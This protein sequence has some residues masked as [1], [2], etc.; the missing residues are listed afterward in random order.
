MIQICIHGHFYQPSRVNPWTDQWARQPSAAPF[1]DWNSRIS[2]ECYA[3]NSA[4]RLLD[5]SGRTRATRNNYRFMSFDFGPTL[6][7]WMQKNRPALLRSIAQSDKDSIGLHGRGTAMAQAY[8]HPI[9]P[10]CDDRDRRLEIKWGLDAFEAVFS[11][12][13]RGLWMPE[14]AMDTATLEEMARQGVEF[15]VVDSHQIQRYRL[16][17]GSAWIDAD[18]ESDVLGHAYLVELPSGASITLVPYSRDLSHGVAFGGWLN[19]GG[20][21]ADRLVEAG[22]ETGFVILATDGESYGHHHRL[23]EMALAYAIEQLEKNEDVEFTTVAR[24]LA[25]NPATRRAEIR[26]PSSWSCAHGVERWRSDCGCAINPSSGFRQHW[27]GPLRAA[28]EWLRDQAREHL[29]PVGSTLLNDPESALEEYGAHL[30]SG[31]NFE[32]WVTPYLASGSS[33]VPQAQIWFDCHRHLL[34]MFTSCAWFFDD[35]TGL[36]PQQNVRHAACAVG[37]VKELTGADLFEGFEHHVRQIPSNTESTVLVDTLHSF[38]HRENHPMRE[39]PGYSTENRTAGV[40]HPV[41]AFNCPG[42]IGSLDGG[43]E[44]VDWMSE[45]GL[46]IWQILPLCPSDTFGSPYSS[47]SALSGDPTLVGLKWL[48][49]MELLPAQSTEIDERVVYSKARTEKLTAVLA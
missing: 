25:D 43:R 35:S 28:F 2:A 3:P 12:P 14:T 6:L 40:L 30:A 27:R 18:T 16:K 44:F 46:K 21:F 48:E 4:A 9:L 13:A 24:W 10:L 37:L 23:G 17:E 11:R 5:A 41:T 39:V 32:T 34:A 47:W 1:Y 8:H 33:S 49:G 31:E 29:A 15:T 20:D 19:E 7:H 26:E 42:P 22:E 38:A 45:V 36:E